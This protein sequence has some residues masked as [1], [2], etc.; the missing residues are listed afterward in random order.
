MREMLQSP[1]Q[2]VI[3]GGK[4]LFTACYVEFN[5]CRRVLTIINVKPSNTLMLK[6]LLKLDFLDCIYCFINI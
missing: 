2:T 1:Y 6:M 3:D 5:E 4:V